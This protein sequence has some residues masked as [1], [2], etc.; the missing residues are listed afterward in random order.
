MAT[1]NVLDWNKKKVGSVEVPSEVF[2]AEVRKELLHRIVNWQLAGRRQ[3]THKTKTRG[4]V[5]GGGKKPFKQKGTGNARQGSIRSPLMPGGGVA[6]GPVPRDYSYTLPK[7][8]KQAAL[9]C[10]LSY[11]NKENKLFVIDDMSS[12]DGK[13]KEIAKRLEGF[14]ISKALLI[15]ESRDEKFQ[16]ATRN[17]KK[18]HYNSVEGLNVFDL[19]RF[20]TA[21]LTQRSLEKIISRCTDEVR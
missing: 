7:K 20:D 4:E 1:L 8:L 14:G 2:E 3:G 6:F 19:L 11:L 12:V 9:R 16:R 10:A 18:I 17:L 5:R 13:T 15:D 21:I